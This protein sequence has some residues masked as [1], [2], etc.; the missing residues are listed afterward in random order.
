MEHH[1]LIC[2]ITQQ[3]FFEPV[4][5]DDGYIYEKDAINEWIKMNQISPMTRESITEKVISVQFIKTIVH[6]YLTKNPE[7]KA[8]Q[9]IGTK[10]FKKH[11]ITIFNYIKNHEFNKLL[12]YEYYILD[13][14]E[15]NKIKINVKNKD[16]EISFLKYLIMNCHDE[17]IITYMI[18]NLDYISSPLTLYISQYSTEEIALKYVDH[19]CFDDITEFKWN[20]L[21][22]FVKRNFSKVIEEIGTKLSFRGTHDKTRKKQTPIMMT[23]K[24]NKLHILNIMIQYDMSILPDDICCAITHKLS[25][26]TIKKM[27][28]KCKDSINT[29][30]FPLISYIS[31]YGQYG[32]YMDFIKHMLVT[33]PLKKDDNNDNNDENEEECEEDYLNLNTSL[34]ADLCKITSSIEILKMVIDKGFSV[35]TLNKDGYSGWMESLHYKRFKVFEYM[36]PKIDFTIKTEY[37]S[38][39]IHWLAQSAKYNLLKKM[40]KNYTFDL[41]EL[42]DNQTPLLYAI[43]HNN[44]KVC[45]LLINNGADV[46][47]EI[48]GYS[49]LMMAIKHQSKNFAFIK[50]L[51]NTSNSLE[52]IAFNGFYPIH[53]VGLYGTREL[54][55]F[56]FDMNID[57]HTKTRFGRNLI[58]MLSMRKTWDCSDLIKYLIE[59]KKMDIEQYDM[60]GF[61]PIHYVMLYGSLEMINYMK[62]ITK[63]YK[64]NT[65]IMNSNYHTLVKNDT[66]KKILKYNNNID[67]IMD[68]PHIK[69][70]I[71]K[72]FDL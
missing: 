25:Y 40:L 23:I 50:S 64:I 36:L 29:K 44:S 8:R 13:K 11:S 61:K 71:K 19:F 22:F 43:E 20:V 5:A 24:Q 2:P 59:V 41:N 62:K 56:C 35:N 60:I 42:V 27:Y 32:G 48:K 52:T 18:D 49:H 12:D 14:L 65:Y 37:G 34:V 9:Y 6:D 4:V 31:K 55:K 70:K 26:D 51:I 68:N 3:V 66:V 10:E 53:Y 1:N 46:N 63:N 72:A 39:M 30:F 21:H 58:C 57:L 16:I 69:N 7:M 54:I 17:T 28:D 38:G 15:S 45:Q 67:L 33:A 47:I